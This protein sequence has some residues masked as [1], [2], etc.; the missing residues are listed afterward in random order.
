MGRG[1]T[2]TLPAGWR[3]LLT[4][5]VG[6]EKYPPIWR[7]WLEPKTRTTDLRHPVHG[8]ACGGH[9]AQNQ[10]SLTRGSK[11]GFLTQSRAE[12]VLCFQTL[13]G[14]CLQIFFLFMTWQIIWLEGLVKWKEGEQ[15]NYQLLSPSIRAD[16]N[17]QTFTPNK[18]TPVPKGR[19]TLPQSPAYTIHLKAKSK[20]CLKSKFLPVASTAYTL[21]PA[22]QQCTPESMLC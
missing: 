21:V 22:H 9:P 19:E 7:L 11:R 20:R 1:K 5:N 4:G 17:F 6:L 8:C 12:E 16:L 18:S 2:N 13:T 15:C 14:F 10:A 3:A